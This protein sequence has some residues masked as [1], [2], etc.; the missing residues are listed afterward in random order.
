MDASKDYYAILGV[1]P[2]IEQTALKAVY[3]ALLKK[4][5]PDVYKGNISDAERIT[6]Q[7]NEAYSILGDQTRR[8]E[9]D[10]LR[11][12]RNSNDGDFSQE[13][14]SE[15][16]DIYDEELERN[17]KYI[18]DYYPEAEN[19]RQE[20]NLISRSLSITFQLIIITEKLSE[21]SK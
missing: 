20:L 2:S 19:Y 18:A 15:S 12:T 9:Y 6:K 14:N 7:L 4:Y 10:A 1:L 16:N 13:P 17:W 5:H 3:L 21:R 8:A 11:K